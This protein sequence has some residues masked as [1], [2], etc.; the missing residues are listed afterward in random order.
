MIDVCIL[1]GKYTTAHTV[2]NI[3]IE[4]I[5]LIR[6]NRRI[7][8]DKPK[9]K[10]RIGKNCTTMR[11]P[12]HLLKNM[13][14]GCSEI[15]PSVVNTIYDNDQGEVLAQYVASICLSA[16]AKEINDMFTNLRKHVSNELAHILCTETSLF[17]V[18]KFTKQNQSKRSFDLFRNG[19]F[20]RKFWYTPPEF[21]SDDVQKDLTE[22]PES[23][24]E[25]QSLLIKHGITE[26]NLGQYWVP[27]PKPCPLY[28]MYEKLRES[29][30]A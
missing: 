18:K 6:A 26:D 1:W 3:G 29:K 30:A 4:T 15:T 22:P 21:L 25:F 27:L 5:P 16:P 10:R 19:V 23:Q 13:T 28:C 17:S 8:F 11:K 14:F 9:D 20:L 12:L 7:V 24:T 2:F